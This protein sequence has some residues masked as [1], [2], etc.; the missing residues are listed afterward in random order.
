MIGML[1][2]CFLRLAVDDIVGLK[3][4]DTGIHCWKIAGNSRTIVFL[5]NHMHLEVPAP[6]EAEEMSGEDSVATRKKWSGRTT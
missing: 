5:N 2:R 1:F 4:D 6:D 3:T